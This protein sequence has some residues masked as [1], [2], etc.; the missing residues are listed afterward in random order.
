MTFAD[1]ALHTLP[2]AEF[3]NGE[4]FRDQLPVN[5]VDFGLCLRQRADWTR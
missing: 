5:H 4:L 1:E 2:A 3:G